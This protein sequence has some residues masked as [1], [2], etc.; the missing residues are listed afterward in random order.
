MFRY[1]QF[2]VLGKLNHRNQLCPS[3]SSCKL[4]GTF[5]VKNR[6]RSNAFCHSVTQNQLY[7]KQ[8]FVCKVFVAEGIECCIRLYSRVDKIPFTIF[9]A[10]ATASSL[11]TS[12]VF[13]RNTLERERIVGSSFLEF[14]QSIMKYTFCGGSSRSFKNEF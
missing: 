9:F 3:K 5:L 1:F 11:K 12:F 13:R 7:D 8:N 10:P 6:I 14:S 2:C 4:P